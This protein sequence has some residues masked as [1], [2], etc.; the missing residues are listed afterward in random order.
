MSDR[1]RASL[2]PLL[3]WE[4]GL[5]L[6][7]VIIGIAGA[8]VSSEFFTS[9][10]IF[11]LGLSYGEIAIMTLP[12]T[13]IVISGEIDLSVAS[14]LGM[15]SALLGFLWARH[16]P[17]LGIFLLVAVVGL[18]AGAI[19]GLLVTRL[20]L[21]SL[22]VTIGTLAV[23][24]GIATILL[25]PNTV[26][27]FPVTYTNLGVNAFPFTGNDLTYSAAIFIVLAI[28][29]GVV[30]HA[31]PFGRSVYAMGASVEAAQFAGIRVKRNK[32]LL[33][34]TSGLVCALAGVL[35][36][37][38][39]NTAVQNNGLGL[40]LAVVAIVL[41][42]GV[43]IFGGKGTVIGVV[44]GVLA[45]A[46]IQNALFL[47]NFNQEAA[48]I[49][50]GAL[51]L[52]SVF[53]RNAASFSSRLRAWRPPALGGVAGSGPALAGDPGTRPRSH[54]PDRGARSGPRSPPSES[55][56]F[57]EPKIERIQHMQLRQTA[58]L[59]VPL[60]MA[61]VLLAA[62]SSSGSSST[63]TSGASSS[64]SA[65]SSGAAGLKTGLKVF[66]IP[67]NLGNNYFTTADSA[68]TGG[69]IAALSALG[70]TGTETSGTA[71]TPASQIPAIQAAISKGANA[72]IVSATDPTALCPTLNAAMK[73]GITVVTYDS[74]APTCR[75]LF[76][77]QA[78]T[79]QIGTSEVD[80]LAKQLKQTG[81]IAIVSAT[82]SATNQNAW[83]GYMK[84][85]LKKYPKM[86]LV[87]TV[88]GNDDPTT[89]TQVTQGLLQQYPNLMGIISPT[90]VGIAAAAA[91]LD[92]PKYRGK[93]ALTGLGTP[94]SLKKYVSDG[95][96]K[97][98]VLW[99]PND[100]GYLAAYAAVQIASG[101]L[102]GSQGQTFTAGKLGS[103]TVGADKTVL[104]G[105]PFVFTPANIGQ[106]NF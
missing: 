67:K 35:L 36:T 79:A 84:Q 21:P 71:A 14:I 85:E 66:V 51:L 48:G 1:L 88:Y 42:G 18:A 45:F 65:S 39:L 22:A 63:A 97:E 78:S 70:E 7:V 28:V 72:L 103:Y 3:R 98:F 93:I 15:S 102:N 27:N 82:A 12:M 77:N 100:L 49:V 86:K 34:M 80:V 101:K 10:N 8:S 68:K 94:D 30:L 69:A 53:G 43:S 59:A 61:S 26:A 57:S 99:K 32:T 29:F 20:G 25:G 90:T 89:A 37:F 44:L 75:D 83:I 41:L 16:W 23:Y 17:M 19:N 6:V 96:I 91:V 81:D 73:R 56:S 33:F 104:L 40:E 58:G 2:D 47:T 13:L 54:P 38:R 50:T 5:A 92:T 64:S 105:P 55:A 62:C 46:G 31:T 52:L 60:V 106:F 4:T 11:N 76:I 95:T 24:R 87:S 74:D 9:N